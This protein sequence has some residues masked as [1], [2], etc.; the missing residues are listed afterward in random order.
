MDIEQRF[1]KLEHRLFKELHTF[2]I[3]LRSEVLREVAEKL[4]RFEDRMLAE[5]SKRNK[6]SAFVQRPGHDGVATNA[7]LRE[8]YSQQTDEPTEGASRL[9]NQEFPKLSS[10]W[11]KEPAVV[12]Q[13]NEDPSELEKIK[14][15][16]KDPEPSLSVDVVESI[17]EKAMAKLL[18][19]LVTVEELKETTTPEA[20]VTEVIVPQDEVLYQYSYGNYDPLAYQRSPSSMGNFR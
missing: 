9:L 20:E 6:V 1:N 19:N 11:D 18:S 15:S 5:A 3:E 7:E 17:L 14:E 10:P 8:H 12:Q 13:A 4:E 16:K 2:H